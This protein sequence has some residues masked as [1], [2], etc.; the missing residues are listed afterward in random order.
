MNPSG[1]SANPLFRFVCITLAWLPLAFAVWYVLGAD[2]PVAR[3][4]DRARAWYT[5]SSAG[6]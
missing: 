1:S 3:R 4:S 2:H 6:S 5:D